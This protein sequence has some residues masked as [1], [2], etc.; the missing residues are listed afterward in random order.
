MSTSDKI[1]F[2]LHLLSAI[3]AFGPLLVYPMLGASG[4][5]PPPRATQWIVLP[6]LVGLFVFGLAL[7]SALGFE[8]SDPWISLAFLLNLAAIAVA[9]FLLLPTQRQIVDLA[10]RAGGDTATAPLLKRVSMYSGVLHLLLFVAIVDMI[11]KP[12]A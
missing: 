3:A 7:V 2:L 11:W 5:A 12:G 10:D 6:G 1:L 4:V 8:F 9:L